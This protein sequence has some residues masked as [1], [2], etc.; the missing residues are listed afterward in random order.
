MCLVMRPAADAE[1]TAQNISYKKLRIFRLPKSFNS[2][3]R[4][5]V[6]GL[7]FAMGYWVWGLGFRVRVVLCVQSN[8]PSRNHGEQRGARTGCRCARVSQGGS[9]T[10]RWLEL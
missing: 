6:C 8:A 3:F 2:D 9:R 10:N 1:L 4:V 5:G 7:G